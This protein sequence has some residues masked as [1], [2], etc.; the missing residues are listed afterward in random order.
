MSN[1]FSEPLEEGDM[2]NPADLGGWE[3]LDD[4]PPVDTLDIDSEEGA[5]Y[6]G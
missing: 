2:M 5:S 4:V 3:G 1:S 6:L